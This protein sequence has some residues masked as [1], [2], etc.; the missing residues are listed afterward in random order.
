MLFHKPSIGEE[1]PATPVFL[2]GEKR[3]AVRTST[4]IPPEK[5]IAR[6]KREVNEVKLNHYL[7][8]PSCWYDL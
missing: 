4:F 5:R 8:V 7:Y 1:Q 3:Q 6:V 2:S